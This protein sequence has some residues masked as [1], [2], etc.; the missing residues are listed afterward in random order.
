MMDLINMKSVVTESNIYNKTKTK[1]ISKRSTRKLAAKCVSSTKNDG[2]I[3]LCCFLRDCEER[4]T[5]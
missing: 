4:V 3:P 2:L 1:K 5:L